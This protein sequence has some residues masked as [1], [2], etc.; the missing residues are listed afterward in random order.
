[1]GSSI[2]LLLRFSFSTGFVAISFKR[3]ILD[4]I[5][6]YPMIPDSQ[7]HITAIIN[8]IVKEDAGID[9]RAH[10]EGSQAIL[11]KAERD[12]DWYCGQASNLDKM[13]QSIDEMQNLLD[14]RS[15]V[16][17]D[18]N[19]YYNFF[20]NLSAPEMRKYNDPDFRNN[21]LNIYR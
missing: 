4:P 3:P 13:P 8:Y 6:G 2:G 14:Q 15:Y 19:K 1:M 11:E 9:F 20:G 18:Y 7:P 5:T 17:P 16:L 21:R 10:R 12:W